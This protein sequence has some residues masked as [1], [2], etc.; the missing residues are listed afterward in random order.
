MPD[1]IKRKTPRRSPDT[2][3]NPVKFLR[4]SVPGKSME[5]KEGSGGTYEEACRGAIVGNDGSMLV[6]GNGGEG[7]RRG[8]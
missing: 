7:G 1:V 5:D 8:A 6:A 4:E 2:L 3:Q